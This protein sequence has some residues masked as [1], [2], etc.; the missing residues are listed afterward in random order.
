[1]AASIGIHRFV[2]SVF[3]I[4][5]TARE[6]PS[7]SV[8]QVHEQHADFVWR[9]LQRLGVRDSDL[10]DALQD[11]FLVVHR[12]LD[13]FDGSARLTT[14]L[15]GI[16]LRVAAAHRRRAHIRR[17]EMTPDLES[18]QSAGADDPEAA[19]L[20]RESR[21]RLESVLDSMSLE[22]RAV[23][24][25]FE[26]EGLTAVEIAE[27]VGVPVGTVHSRLYAAR[28]E[29]ARAAERWARRDRFGGAP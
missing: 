26:I 22:K 15:Y 29:F 23:F 3:S 10:E 16:A 7:L 6:A 13:T 27:I 18:T 5:R 4:G 8:E 24:V 2:A 11:V 28:G 9:S 20:E 17:E 21:R 1:M 19:L 12:K 14:W 25:M